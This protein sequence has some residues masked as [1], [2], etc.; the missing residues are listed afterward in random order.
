M[1]AGSVV[2]INSAGKVTAGAATG[3]SDGSST[4]TTK[5]YVDAN[6][7]NTFWFKFSR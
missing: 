7:Y 2:F 6:S 4:L 3:S 5:G 1:V